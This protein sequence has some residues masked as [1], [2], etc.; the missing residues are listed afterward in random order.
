MIKS[1]Q[2]PLNLLMAQHSE[3]VVAVAEVT[4]AENTFREEIRALPNINTDA[5]KDK[6]GLDSRIETVEKSPAMAREEHTKLL[7]KVAQSQD[8]TKEIEK[9]T[10]S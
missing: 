6:E 2:E 7:E 8:R 5:A 3:S 9:E 4:A 10:D 1:V